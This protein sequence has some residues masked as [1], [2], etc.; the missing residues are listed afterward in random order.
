MPKIYFYDKLLKLLQRDS[1]NVIDPSVIFDILPYSES[2]KLH[3]IIKNSNLAS[4]TLKKIMIGTKQNSLMYNTLIALSSYLILQH[5]GG[6]STAR[7]FVKWGCG[8]LCIQS[9]TANLKVFEE[10]YNVD[11]I[12][13]RDTVDIVTNIKET[14]IDSVA[15]KKKIIDE[16]LRSIEILKKIYN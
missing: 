14:N 3:N 1:F 9:Q 2:E 10:I 4:N 6:A 7:V 13:F 15:N 8:N 5:R 11:F 12:N 16:E